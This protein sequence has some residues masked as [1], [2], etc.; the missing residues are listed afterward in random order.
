MKEVR[1]QW[2][3]DEKGF[4]CLVYTDDELVGQVEAGDALLIENRTYHSAT[5]TQKI[6]RRKS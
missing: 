6:G 2:E 1:S 3:G 4:W 5:R